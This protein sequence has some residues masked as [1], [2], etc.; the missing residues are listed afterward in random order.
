MYFKTSTFFIKECFKLKTFGS[1]VK[2]LLFVKT[3][4]LCASVH[5][6]LAVVKIK[7]T[8]SLFYQVR[9]VQNYAIECTCQ[10]NLKV[11]L[12]VF[13]LVSWRRGQT[14]VA[15]SAYIPSYLRGIKYPGIFQSYHLENTPQSS[16]IL[17]QLV[18]TVTCMG[19][20]CISE[21]FFHL[22]TPCE[23][24]FCSQCITLLQ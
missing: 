4:S 7:S 22:K 11:C 21:S 24:L 5:G 15:V 12:S 6:S 3:V 8:T 16:R 23:A 20:N 10:T 9:N 13:D 2:L 19:F 1:M 17:R 18:C 14:R